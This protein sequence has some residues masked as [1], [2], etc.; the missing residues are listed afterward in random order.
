MAHKSNDFNYDSSDQELDDNGLPIYSDEDEEQSGESTQDLM[1]M[2]R[3]ARKES[4]EEDDDKND[5]DSSDNQ[6]ES[7]DD[8]KKDSDTT[9]SEDSGTKTKDTGGDSSSG[10]YG[11]TPPSQQTKKHSPSK[12]SAKPSGTD[13]GNWFSNFVN[14][15][16]GGGGAGGKVAGKAGG[17]AAGQA[18]SK[19]GAGIAKAFASMGPYGWLIILIIIA[20]IILIIA[21]VAVVAFFQNKTDPENMRNNT[22]V[23]D[24]YFYGIRVVYID[25]EALLNSLEFSYKQYIVDVFEEIDSQNPSII[26]NVSLPD[27]AT[28]DNTTTLDTHI[29]N[30]S[31]GIANIAANKNANEYANSTFSILCEQIPCFGLSTK[32]GTLANEFILSYINENSLLTSNEEIDVD[33][34]VNTA[35]ESD[36]L[37]YIYNRCEKVMIK[38]E[39]ASATG[40]TGIE[41]RQYVASIY[42]PN[43]D[44]VIESS[45]YTVVN[46]N[47][48]FATNTK[49]IEENNGTQN[50]LRE[51][52]I[53]DHSDIITGFSVGQVNVSKFTCID[54]ENTLAF[55]SGLSLFDAM[56]LKLE[57]N[58]YFTQNEE[59]LIYSWKPNCQSLF[60]LQF[61]ALNNFIFTDFSLNVKLP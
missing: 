38:D 27:E 4:T 50:I 8:N 35:L 54:E 3:K 52:D 30:M 31:M 16:K 9:Q 24:E 37:K 6:D 36:N 53:T 20:I 59:T 21:I 39:I 7:S 18:A 34:I 28:F 15:F 60:Y 57:Y 32:Q 10:R 56:R 51:K 5:T 42:M 11:D 41:Q 33:T 49:L 13:G 23:T 44:I 14:K 61:E 19:A 22:L 48:V 58:Q 43:K 2:I 25:N 29:S 47:E 17:K 1:D 55:S 40:L 45:T 46:E 26:I 12:T